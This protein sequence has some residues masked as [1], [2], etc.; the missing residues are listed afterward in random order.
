VQASTHTRRRLHSN[1]SEAQLLAQL[2]SQ[3]QLGNERW[4][5]ISAFICVICG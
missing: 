1:P 2:R 5:K 4:R 3:A